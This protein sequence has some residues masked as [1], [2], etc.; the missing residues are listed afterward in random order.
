MA[1]NL[2]VSVKTNESQ[3]FLQQYFKLG[4]SATKAKEA[5]LALSAYFKDLASGIRRGAIDVQTSDA[6]PA[7]ASGTFTFVSVIATD[8]FTIAGVTFTFTSTPTLETDVEV[9]GATDALD[10]A[11]AAAAINAHSTISK[12][13]KATRVNNVVTVTCRVPGVIGNF[14]AISDADTTITTSAAYLSGGTG[15]ATDDQATFECNLAA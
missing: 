15:G 2:Q 13:V 7:R 3:A 11:A 14:I 12:I 8:A 1:G 9:D 6:A 10:A 4:S 5:A